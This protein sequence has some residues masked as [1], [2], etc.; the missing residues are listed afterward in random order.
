MSGGKRGVGASLTTSVSFVPFPE[1]K[2]SFD[3]EMLALN[4]CRKSGLRCS[5]LPACRIRLTFFIVSPFQVINRRS[6]I[7]E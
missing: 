6:F 4:R 5:S 2:V 3:P 1:R 7:D